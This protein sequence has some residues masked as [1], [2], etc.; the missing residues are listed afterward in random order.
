M[1][2]RPAGSYDVGKGG[3]GIWRLWKGGGRILQPGR[4]DFVCMMALYDTRR[5]YD[6]YTSHPHLT[7]LP[8]NHPPS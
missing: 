4:M 7:N 6:F 5:I 2:Y 8:V 3:M 1:V